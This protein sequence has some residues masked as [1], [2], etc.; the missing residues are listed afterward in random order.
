[1]PQAGTPAL[2]GTD[3]SQSGLV[4][5]LRSFAD[6]R[7]TPRLVSSVIQECFQMKA[8]CVRLLTLVIPLMLL[9]G[10]SSMQGKKDQTRAGEG[11]GAA[12][13]ETRGAGGAEANTS[14]AR[15]GGWTG[16]PL[17][18]PN[19]PLA[20]RTILFDFDSSTIR[21]EFLPVLRAHAGYLS[22]H[23][24]QRVTL[25][26]HT[27][28]RGTREYNLALGE[29]RAK[30]VMQFLMAEGVGGDQLRTISYGEERPVDP[31]QNE[32]AWARNRR[33]ELVY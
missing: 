12:A 2:A 6:N 21:S 1:M 11:A 8:Q 30:V 5:G 25:E 24:S 22:S 13:V 19:S 18:D 4:G 7:N 26:G 31:G 3:G 14:S 16:N 9:A 17:D 20:T 23:A 29:R 27:D 15:Q 28:E 33:V 32:E 10:C